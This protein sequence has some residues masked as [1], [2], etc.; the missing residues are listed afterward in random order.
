MSPVAT[1]QVAVPF[2]MTSPH[3]SYGE[4]N[5]IARCLMSQNVEFA[6]MMT[7]SPPAPPTEG[8]VAF[9]LIYPDAPHENGYVI[10]SRHAGYTV[11]VLPEDFTGDVRT[12]VIEKDQSRYLLRRLRRVARFIE[13]RQHDLFVAV[14]IKG[15]LSAIE[16]CYEV[17][18]GVH[19]HAPNALVADAQAKAGL[20]GSFADLI[21]G[22]EVVINAAALEFHQ[23]RV[24]GQAAQKAIAVL[25]FLSLHPERGKLAA[26]FDVMF[27]GEQIRA[28]APVSVHLVPP[29]DLTFYLTQP[30]FAGTTA[31][32]TAKAVGRILRD[33]GKRL[34][35]EANS[36]GS[37][38]QFHLS[39]HGA[40]LAYRGALEIYQTF[41]DIGERVPA[42]W[43]KCGLVEEDVHAYW[44][45]A[46]EARVGIMT[47]F[48]CSAV[49]RL[50]G[51]NPA[52]PV[53]CF[54]EAVELGKTRPPDYAEA[55][56]RDL[57]VRYFIPSFVTDLLVAD[58]RLAA[59]QVSEAWRRRV[60]SITARLEAGFDASVHLG[61]PNYLHFSYGILEI[62]CS[63][64]GREAEA[65]HYRSLRLSL[66]ERAAAIFEGGIPV[67]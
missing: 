28:A 53:R 39:L 45:E 5:R 62:Y 19:Y 3:Y 37:I 13:K 20:S 32:A 44:I 60:S 64:L 56:I 58:A 65:K 34:C 29:M 31:I 63:Q 50:R 43:G 6:E 49:P 30:P 14:D 40:L 42:I 48:S 52:R 12:V 55:A 61:E 38:E 8:E 23:T 26:V 54:T 18:E 10:A 41:K 7:R 9:R 47:A 51:W 46:E 22:I 24:D 67:A 59:G 2:W 66:G 16:R 4:F 15:R 11:A 21:G 35:L 25:N 36:A 17:G 57:S 27:N 33:R 1:G